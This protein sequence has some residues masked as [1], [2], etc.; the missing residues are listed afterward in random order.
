MTEIEFD[1][2][3]ADL[4]DSIFKIES[5]SWLEDRR[6]FLAV[7]NTVRSRLGR[8]VYLECGS[9]IGGSLLP[10]ILDPRCRLAYS[11]DKRP[12]LQPDER[13][14]DYLY[15]DNSA[16]RMI[17]NLALHAT[18]DSMSKLRTFDVDA[19]AL[20]SSQI[21]EQPDLVMI[22]AEHTNSAVFSDFLNLYKLCHDSTVYVFHD[23]N[24]IFSGLQNIETFMRYSGVAFDSYV[25]PKVV[26]VLAL[27]DARESLRPIGEQF[28]L[29][30]DEFIAMSKQQLMMLHYGFVRE[31][32]A[33][34]QKQGI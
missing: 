5:E 13:G 8:Y 32:L 23:A 6:S 19:S 20:T 31:R 10:H 1:R 29:D 27:N 7:Q 12:P 16:Q 30:Q 21:S 4:D 34:E 11:V 3:I 9:H 22:D 15:P 14:I 26:Y 28:G 33:G 25:L 2:L 24:L 18:A 17:A